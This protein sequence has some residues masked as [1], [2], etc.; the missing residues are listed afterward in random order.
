MA[1]SVGNLAIQISGNSSG[2]IREFKNVERQTQHFGHVINRNI[3]YNIKQASAAI[4]ESS[5]GGGLLG[6]MLGGIG[7]GLRSGVGAAATAAAAGLTAVGV[8]TAAAGARA[9]YLAAGYQAAA[10]AFEVMTGSAEK[11]IGL[12]ND[13]Q[14]FAAVTPF[15]SKE[16]IE[17]G[18]MLMGFGVSASNVLPTLQAIGEVTAG[19]GGGAERLQ[20]IAL[21]YG[22]VMSAGKFMGTE[23]RQ[24]VEAGVGANEFAMTL[25]VTTVRFREMMEAGQI[26]SEVVSRTFNR[27]TGQGGRFSG[28]M[29]KLSR[30]ASGRWNTIRE[31]A[32]LALQGVGLKILENPS[33]TEFFDYL[34]NLTLRI[35]NNATE[36][37]EA[38]SHISTL[39]KTT[40]IGME[41]GGKSLGQMLGLDDLSDLKSATYH[42]Q[43]LIMGV[44]ALPAAFRQSGTWIGLLLE[45][46]SLDIAEFANKNRWILAPSGLLGDQ[47]ATA[48]SLA[49]MRESW[50]ERV[51]NTPDNFALAIEEQQRK[52]MAANNPAE[53]GKK[54]G[55]IEE[56]GPP[57]PWY[58][59]ELQKANK[60]FEAANSG[61]GFYY[62]FRRTQALM[63]SAD[64]AGLISREAAQFSMLGAFNELRKTVG[65]RLEIKLPPAAMAG[66]QE[67]Q[68]II[69]RSMQKSLSVE[70]E[71]RRILEE[72]KRLKEEQ[73]D[74]NKRQL[75]ELMRIARNPGIMAGKI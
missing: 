14:G 50:S 58:A 71:V 40:L 2:L 31:N 65:D 51:K 5:G 16:L 52:L 44:A 17:T 15:Q 24:F 33:T 6:S 61:R 59:D 53:K 28:L 68:D 38:F 10:T 13:I 9:V 37:G 75:D 23:L 27:L 19:A 25:G 46:W 67:A 62:E 30:N 63:M 7:S 41:T 18:R 32:D 69:N 11:G 8:A 48:E 60:A 20:R 36:V 42:I 4:P 57:R 45:G 29:D 34:D 56:K 26:G 22:Q 1:G 39:A 49:R 66:S 12:L 72:S 55:Q 3:V 21:A 70:E 47:V 74:L 35:K 43:S 73:K 64:R 54:P